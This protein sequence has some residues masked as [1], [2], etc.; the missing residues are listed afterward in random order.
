MQPLP[1]FTI[2]VEEED[3]LDELPELESCVEPA[4]K[5]SLHCARSHFSA[6]LQAASTA[7]S[8]IGYDEDEGEVFARRSR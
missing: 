8:T 3:P 4:T 2:E 1:L 5:A 7:R 6:I